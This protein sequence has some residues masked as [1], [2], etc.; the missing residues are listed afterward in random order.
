MSEHDEVY[1]AFDAATLKYAVAIAEGGLRSR[2]QFR[3]RNVSMTLR[4]LWS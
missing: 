3:K 2:H 1:V 4:H